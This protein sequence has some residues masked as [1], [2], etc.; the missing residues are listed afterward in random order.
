MC[1]RANKDNNGCP[2][3]ESSVDIVPQNRLIARQIRW[4]KVR[5]A[6]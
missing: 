4:S 2:Q 1:V 6:T 5:I 3:R